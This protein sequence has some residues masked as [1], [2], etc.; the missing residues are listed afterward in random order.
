MTERMSVHM[1]DSHPTEKYSYRQ[2][3]N[4]CNTHTHSHKGVKC[5]D[6]GVPLP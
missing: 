2:T 4:A 1:S 6:G 5:L 3:Q